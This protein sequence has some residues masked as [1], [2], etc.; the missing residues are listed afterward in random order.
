MN[1]IA[2]PKSHQLNRLEGFALTAIFQGLPTQM[3]HLRHLRHRLVSDDQ[4]IFWKN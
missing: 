1:A 4:H 2:A 3:T